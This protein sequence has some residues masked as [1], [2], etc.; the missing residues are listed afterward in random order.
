MTRSGES[1]SRSRTQ[2]T[3]WRTL[4]PANVLRESPDG[5]A[6]L[7]YGNLPPARLE[8][9][10]WFREPSL[11]ELAHARPA[12]SPRVEAASE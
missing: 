9:R 12:S 4:A 10:P 7:V 1:G 11:R 5:T 6:I 3:S 2:S 8:L